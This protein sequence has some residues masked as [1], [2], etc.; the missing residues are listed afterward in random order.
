MRS[1]KGCSEKSRVLGTAGKDR[2]LRLL[3]GMSEKAFRQGAERKVLRVN[4]D[5]KQV[6]CPG[7]VQ[8]GQ[9]EMARPGG[10]H[11]GCA[12]AFP[13]GQGDSGL[14]QRLLWETSLWNPA[15]WEGNPQA[16]MRRS[17]G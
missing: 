7:E 5:M 17:D 9:R 8:P 11:S 6:Q 14:E 12:M 10:L 2:W 3:F 15:R 13:G 16:P 1:V 4:G